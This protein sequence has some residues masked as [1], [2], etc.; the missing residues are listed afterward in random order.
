MEPTLPP[1]PSSGPIGPIPP[2]GSPPPSPASLGGGPVPPTGPPGYR[3]QPGGPWVANVPP[4][5]HGLATASLVCG[6]VGLLLFMLLAVLPILALIFGLISRSAIARSNGALIGAGRA[7]AGVALGIVGI[8]FFGL[9]AWAVATDRIGGDTDDTSVFELRVGNCVETL[10]PEN[11]SVVTLPVVECTEP[12]AAEV[13][14]VTQ[15][16]ADRDRD[17]PGD[18]EVQVEADA[19][20]LARFEGYVGLPYEESVFEYSLIVPGEESWR[21]SRGE[22]TCLLFEPGNNAVVG[23]AYNA[24]R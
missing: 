1:P 7:K 23:S 17:Y 11:A 18:S 24:R 3:W 16:N 14:R 20:C 22:V 19:M 10:V 13:F 8:V 4:R 6:L 9:F 12:H 2:F 21:A 5:T 15:L